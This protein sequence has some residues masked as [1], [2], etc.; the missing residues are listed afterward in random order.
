MDL[1]T[2]AAITPTVVVSHPLYGTCVTGCWLQMWEVSVC[3][4]TQRIESAPLEGFMG[5]ARCDP[6]VPF[7]IKD[8]DQ[9]IFIGG[10]A[11]QNLACMLATLLPKV[12]ITAFLRHLDGNPTNNIA[13]NLFWAESWEGMCLRPLYRSLVAYSP[14]TGEELDSYSDTLSA[15]I[16]IVCSIRHSSGVA[17]SVDKV[18]HNLEAAIA[19]SSGCSSGGDSSS[20][21]VLYGC[22]WRVVEVEVLE[23]E[24]WH[25][26]SPY[27]GGA[28]LPLTVMVSNR[29]RMLRSNSTVSLGRKDAVY[30]QHRYFEAVFVDYDNVLKVYRLPAA[31]AVF[32][33]F[34]GPLPLERRAVMREGAPL[35][36]DGTYR[37][38]AEDI[39]TESVTRRAW[40]EHACD[41]PEEMRLCKDTPVHYV[42]SREVVVFPELA[43]A[44]QVRGGV[45]TAFDAIFVPTLGSMAWFPG[46]AVYL[47]RPLRECYRDRLEGVTARKMPVQQFVWTV[48]AGRELPEGCTVRPKNLNEA[49][50]RLCNLACVNHKAH[51]AKRPG[52]QIV[53]RPLSEKCGMAVLPR[54]VLLQHAADATDGTRFVLALPNRPVVKGAGPH[55]LT[56]KLV[57]ILTEYYEAKGR[58]FSS[59]YAEYARLV[60]EF[61]QISTI[62]KETASMWEAARSVRWV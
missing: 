41:M 23:D 54:H 20:R 47:T 24:H 5:M 49:D 19:S 46:D 40:S 2:L 21:P 28:D 31:A 48:L 10:H 42:C 12:P 52:T 13:T 27:I 11:Q 17:P 50:L 60:L 6:D 14:I 58:D 55:A 32:K 37:C 39:E 3:R 29:G 36:Q 43:C 4:K 16:A 18:Q 22:R 53:P 57:P 9:R 33:V 15:A 51:H 7:L 61:D 34:V 35:L 45:V 59:E 8:P 44:A 25:S 62:T 30:P 1:A 38:W 56:E 26:H